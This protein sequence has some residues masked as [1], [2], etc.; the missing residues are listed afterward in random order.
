MRAMQ[1]AE[2][3]DCFR[4]VAN[5]TEVKH[6]NR[7]LTSGFGTACSVRISIA[8]NGGFAIGAA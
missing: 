7:G 1:S 8:A 4:R 2:V 5:L 3:P 6:S